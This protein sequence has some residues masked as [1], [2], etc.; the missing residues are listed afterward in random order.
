MPVARRLI[1]RGVHPAAGIAFMLAA[2]IVNPVV[3]ASTWV[4]YNGS[5]NAFEMTAARAGVGVIVAL[6]AGLALRRVV[7]GLPEIRSDHN[8][9]GDCALPA[10]GI[11]AVGEHLAADAL[12]MGKFLV[13]GAAAVS[14]SADRGPARRS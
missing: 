2:P 14:V 13:L 7:A 10:R 11:A 8:H 12:F 3:L 1:A 5:G 4:A 9:G 6:A